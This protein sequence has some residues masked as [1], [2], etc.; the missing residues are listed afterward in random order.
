MSNESLSKVLQQF[1]TPFTNPVII[2]TLLI[3]IVLIAP[4]LMAKIKAPHIIGFILAGVA[5]GPHGF[6]LL[7]KNLAVDLLATIGLLYIMFIAGI[8]LDLAEFKNK[9]HKSLVFG[10][11][12][13]A[14]PIIIGF[15]VCYWLLNL[16]F[17]ASVLTASMFATHTLVA[18]PIVSKYKIAGNEAVALTVGGTMLTDTAVLLILPV[19]IGAKQGSLNADF[20]LLLAV[21]VVVFAFIVLQIM[22]RIA[23]W[24]LKR[25]NISHTSQYVFVLACMFFSAMLAQLAG[26][27]PIIGAFVGALAL[28]KLVPKQS[29]LFNNVTFVGNAIFIPV[30]LI[31]VGMVVNLHVLFRGPWALI[32]A[33]TLTLVAL[34]GK[35]A[36]SLFT[37]KIF[38]YTT[39][40]RQLIFG[41]SSSHAAAT[42]AIIL[43]GYKSKIIDD[44]VLNGT[45]VLILVTCMVASFTVERAGKKLSLKTQ[46]EHIETR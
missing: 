2:F 21:S 19:I 43:V 1:H 40:Q 22:P 42:L 39:L 31:S 46:V 14:I 5:I 7:T 44:D 41:L 37:Q 24:F 45:I 11:F 34:L 8:E 36:A 16:P 26:V 9:K 15:P 28:N 12:T 13:F 27:E 38:G 23:T 35:W 25:P 30:F 6:N 20:W 32:I 4:L 18:Y 10:I 3:I 33:A 17:L 29:Q